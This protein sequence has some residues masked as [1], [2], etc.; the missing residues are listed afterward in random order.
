MKE[1]TEITKKKKQNVE[2]ENN[3]NKKN[4]KIYLEKVIKKIL[5]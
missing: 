5:K 3:G 1:N 2:K 4:T